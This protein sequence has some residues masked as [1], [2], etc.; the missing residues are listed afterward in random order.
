MRKRIFSIAVLLILCMIISFTT[1]AANS[2]FAGD[3]ERLI[4]AADILSDNEE[5]ELLNKLDEISER[6]NFEIVIAVI[7]TLEGSTAREYADDIYDN[8]NYGYGSDKDGVLLLVSM[9][10][11]DWWISTHG[12]GTRVFTDVG[13]EYLSEQFVYELSN[14]NYM[15]GFCT[16][17]EQCDDFITQARTGEPFDKKNLPREPLGLSWFLISL[18]VGIVLS[19]IIVG[20]MK[21]KLKTVRNQVAANSYIKEDSME[22]T[23]S[24]DLFLYRKVDRT[25]KEKNNSSGS[26]THTSS[27]GKTHGGGGGKF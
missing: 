7:D 15:D 13:I 12:F 5:K 9:E 26:S 22:V 14:E 8:C 24:R 18:A 17:I 6:Q 19:L 16:Y 11:Q 20:N 25:V 4:D 23:E 21:S 3:Y 27:S 10:E 1:F 2:G